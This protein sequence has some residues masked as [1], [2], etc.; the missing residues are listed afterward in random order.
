MRKKG[1]KVTGGSNTARTATFQAGGSYTANEHVTIYAV[2]GN[3]M[4]TVDDIEV[5]AL[6]LDGGIYNHRLQGYS[7][8]FGWNNDEFVTNCFRPVVSFPSGLRVVG[9]DGTAGNP[10]Q[11]AQ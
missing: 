7:R 4:I 9:G 11:L 10:Y 6:Q 8:Y 2:W 1:L 5:R 3:S